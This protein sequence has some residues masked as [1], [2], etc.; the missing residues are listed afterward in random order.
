MEESGLKGCMTNLASEAPNFFT[1]PINLRGLSE[2]S[3]PDTRNERQ[4]QERNRVTPLS[5][6]LGEFLNHRE[7]TGLLK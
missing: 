5:K 4:F 2:V 7:N 3:Q 1:K 6:M